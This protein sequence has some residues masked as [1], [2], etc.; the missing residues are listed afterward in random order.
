MSAAAVLYD[1]APWTRAVSR[2]RASELN[3]G[4]K[5]AGVVVS[6]MQG[7]LQSG[8]CTPD[9]DSEVEPIDSLSDSPSYM[10]EAAR[11]LSEQCLRR[12]EGTL[13]PLLSR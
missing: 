6:G 13:V 11:A 3:L 8:E 9:F 2:G 5:E 4:P 10:K 1:A 12:A 7:R